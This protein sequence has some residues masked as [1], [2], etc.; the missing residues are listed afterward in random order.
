MQMTN[1]TV[2][3]NVHDEPRSF[4][5]VHNL[6]DVPGLRIEDALE[7][8]L[9]R[10]DDYS[11]DS[12]VKYIRSKETDYSVFTEDE[13]DEVTKPEKLWKNN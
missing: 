8:W 9:A 2:N 11:A 6:P 12:F 7:N 4:N 1:S 5:I 3:F 13:F 10:T